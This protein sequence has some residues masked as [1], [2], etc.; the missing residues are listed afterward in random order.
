MKRA[1]G[2]VSLWLERLKLWERNVP[3]EIIHT[4]P[5]MK[6]FE[7]K[8]KER[9]FIRS[10]EVAKHKWSVGFI[11]GGK[12]Y[13]LTPMTV[14][15]AKYP[16]LPIKVYKGLLRETY[17]Q[18]EVNR[19]LRRLEDKYG[20]HELSEVRGRASTPTSYRKTMKKLREEFTSLQRLP[21]KYVIISPRLRDEVYPPEV[22]E[23]MVKE[24]GGVPTAFFL[25]K[26]RYATKDKL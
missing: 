11:L 13:A 16:L 24:I 5:G 7:K 20:L 19:R 14:L 6:N 9:H 4:S 2:P 18:K 8:I 10:E 25:K 1:K 15:S 23:V 17:S 22:V 26:F 12:I 21:G 3:T